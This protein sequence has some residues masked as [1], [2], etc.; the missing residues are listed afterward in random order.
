MNKRIKLKKG[1]LHKKCDDK[2]VN[3]RIIV[4]KKLVTSNI[5][6]G[7]KYRQVIHNI[8]RK[9]YRDN[10]PRYKGEC[11]NCGTEFYACKSMG[12]EIGWIDTGYGSCIKCNTS[13]ALTFDEETNTVSNIPWDEYRKMKQVD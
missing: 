2:C 7:C 8:C 10:R 6:V 9:N 11:C 12:I 13:I 4:E 3:H 5:C 1:I